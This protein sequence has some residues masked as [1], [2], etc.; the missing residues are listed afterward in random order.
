M[1]P[2]AAFLSKVCTEILPPVSEALRI[3]SICF[4]EYIPCGPGIIFEV[5][6]VL[7]GDVGARKGDLT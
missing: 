5:L 3:I 6:A 1:D 4:S 7:L 2:L